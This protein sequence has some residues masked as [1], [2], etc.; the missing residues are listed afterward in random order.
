MDAREKERGQSLR[1]TAFQL[2]RT[3]GF[4]YPGPALSRRRLAQLFPE[5]S[6]NEYASVYFELLDECKKLLD[7]AGE[8]AADLWEERVSRLEALRQLEER[9]PGFSL[10]NYDFA[11]SYWSSAF[12]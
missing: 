3:H 6:D 11:L 4:S 2:L 12:R 7:G 8:I 1:D 10:D 9:F 5:V